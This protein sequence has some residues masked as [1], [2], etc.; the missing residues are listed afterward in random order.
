MSAKQSAPRHRSREAALQALYA[1]DMSGEAD[2]SRAQASLEALAEHFELPAGA[3]AFAKELVLGVASNRDDIDARITAVA[4]RW[5]LE[6]MAAVDRNVLRLAAYEIVYADTPREVAIDEAVEL[7]RR[8][9]D[10]ASPRFVNGVL[11]AL[12]R[13]A[14]S[15]R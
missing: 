13:A 3:R 7:A 15:P 6:R 8:F 11:D 10:D 9:G 12:A 4:H 5:R 1:A 14:E 2:L